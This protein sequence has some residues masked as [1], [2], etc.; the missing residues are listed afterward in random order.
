MILKSSGFF[1]ISSE[2]CFAG[3]LSLLFAVAG[4]TRAR[5]CFFSFSM[6]GVVA[7]RFSC[8]ILCMCCLF[9]GFMG[10]YTMSF[11]ER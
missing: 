6:F 11:M 2:R 8:G 3:I 9:G 5:I 7:S 1:S 10:D 4:A